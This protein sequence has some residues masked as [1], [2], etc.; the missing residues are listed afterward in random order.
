MKIDLNKIEKENKSLDELEVFDSYFLDNC[1]KESGVKHD[2]EYTQDVV[3]L[4]FADGNYNIPVMSLGN[5]SLTIGAAKSKKTFYTTMIASAFIKGFKF[6]MS[7]DLMGRKL[8]YIDTEQSKYHCQKIVKRLVKLTGIKEEN[9]DFLALRKFPEP[10]LRIA[11]IKRML[12][13]NFG[14]YQVVI[15]DGIVD[16]VYDFN[17]LKESTVITNKLMAWS[18]I[19]DC[20][21]NFILH[22]NKDG[23]NARGHLGSIAIQKSEVVFKIVKQDEVFSE[24]S[25]DASRNKSFKSFTFFIDDEGLPIRSDDLF[26]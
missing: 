5:I 22:T 6:M 23:I 2:D 12:E 7:G 21:I 16:L 18:E 13:T 24:V 1:I 10:E 4:T 14:M 25:C 9:F 20:H 17:N 19:Y 3:I 11:I 26:K 15:I 8:L